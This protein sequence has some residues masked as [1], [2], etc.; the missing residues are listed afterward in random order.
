MNEPW[1]S[2]DL[3]VRCHWL[4]APMLTQGM[5]EQAWAIING[6]SEEVQ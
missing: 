4:S 2:A 6:F 1:F 3:W 5:A